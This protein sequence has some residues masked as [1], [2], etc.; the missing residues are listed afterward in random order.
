MNRFSPLTATDLDV[1][2]VICLRLAAGLIPLGSLSADTV[3]AASFDLAELSSVTGAKL[4]A[5][6]AFDER[7]G[8]K[9][10]Q[11]KMK[12]ATTLSKRLSSQTLEGKLTHQ[13]PTTLQPQ[14]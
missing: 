11:G 8:T 3:A 12:S 6:K 14:E 10:G 1:C 9:T 13:Q 5:E 2:L 7:S 4:D